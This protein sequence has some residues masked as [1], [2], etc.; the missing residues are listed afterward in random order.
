MLCMQVCQLNQCFYNNNAIGLGRL[1]V[2]H[3]SAVAKHWSSLL[4]AS[5][6]DS[7]LSRQR[8]ARC[9]FCLTSKSMNRRDLDS[10]SVQKPTHYAEQTP[11]MLDSLSAGHCAN[12]VIYCSIPQINL[13]TV[14]VRLFLFH[15]GRCYLS[16]KIQSLQCHIL[17]YF[18]TVTKY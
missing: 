5:S 6:N 11:S 7:E 16:G 4:M 17:Q 13:K 15:K 14:L 2:T 12:V 9:I 1:T 18:Q 3:T 8:G 10:C